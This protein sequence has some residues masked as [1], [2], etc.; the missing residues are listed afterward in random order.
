M[1]DARDVAQQL[2]GLEKGAVDA[3]MRED[4]GQRERGIR[5]SQG[6]DML[7]IGQEGLRVPREG[8]QGD[9]SRELLL[10]IGAG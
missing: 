7:G 6:R 1:P 10:A 9:R 3:V 5:L 8:A 4:A 2:A